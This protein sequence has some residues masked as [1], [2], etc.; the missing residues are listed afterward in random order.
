MTESSG[1][2][3]LLARAKAELRQVMRERLRLLSPVER[4]RASAGVMRIVQS[5]PLWRSA[6]RVAMFAPRPDEPDLEP[7]LAESCAAGLAVYLPRSTSFEAGY[8]FARVHHWPGDLTIGAYGLREPGPHCPPLDN[9]QLDLILVPGLA[10]G[11]GGQRLGRGKGYYDRLLPQVGGALCG[12]GFDWQVLPVV[13]AGTQDQQLDY[14][15]TPTRW[16]ACGP[17]AA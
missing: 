5:N 12:V 8:Q 4:T 14:I 13:P 10:F 17:R 1:P 16:I 2:D 9:K 15:A 3:S 11:L 7:L 6:R